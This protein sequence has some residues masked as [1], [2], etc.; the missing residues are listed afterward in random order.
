MD[1]TVYKD[2]LLSQLN[3]EIQRLN[4]AGVPFLFQI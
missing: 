3:E 1:I 4:G 2:M